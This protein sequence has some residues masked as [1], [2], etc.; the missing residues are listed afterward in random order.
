MCRP[1]YFEGNHAMYKGYFEKKMIWI[2]SEKNKMFLMDSEKNKLFAIWPKI[3]YTKY[4][5]KN[6]RRLR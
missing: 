6:M 5:I 3:M 4:K 2:F 1:I